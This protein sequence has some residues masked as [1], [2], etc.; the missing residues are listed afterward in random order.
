MHFIR[1]HLLVTTAILSALCTGP[2]ARAQDSN[3]NQASQGATLAPLI[4]QSEENTDPRGAI[5]GYVAKTSATASKTGTPILETQ[6]SISVITRDEI[7]AQA[8]QTLGE[9]LGYTPGVVAEPYGSDP[10]FDSPIVRGFDG[11]QMQYLNGLRMMRTAGAPPVEIYGLERVD[12][13]RGPASVMYGQGN[14]GGIINQ[15]SKRPRFENFGEAGLQAGSYDNYGAFFDV[16]GVIA[17]HDDL[18]YRL[19]GL[20]RLANAQTDELDNDRYFIAPA[21]TWKPDEDTSLT[22]LTSVQHDNPSTPSGLPPQYVI[23][24]SG[25]KLPRDFYVGD[26]DFDHSSRTLTN[27]GYE[28]EKQLNETWAF[29]QNVRYSNLDWDYRSLGMSTLGL[30]ADGRTLR[31]NATFQDESLNT[32]NVDNNLTADFSTGQLEHKV[33][34]GFDYRYFDNN[35]RTRFFQATPLDVLAPSYGGPITLISPT[36]DTRVNSDLSQ[37]GI[38]VQDE[39]AYD[40]W[41]ATLGLRQDWASTSGTSL[42]GLTGVARSLDQDDHKLTGRAGISYLFDGGIAPY[43]S[44]ATSF[45]PVAG[46]STL[47]G[48][49]YKPTEGKQWEA[50]VKYQ[51]EGWNGFFSAAVYDLKQK[52]VLRTVGGVSSQIGEVH[53]KGAELEGVVSLAQGLDLHAAYTYTDAEIGAGTDDGNRVENVPRNAASLWLNYTF[54]ED[55]ALA[56][57]G[58]GGGVRHVGQRYGNSANTYDLDG[59]TLFDAAITYRKDGFNASLNVQNIADEKYVASCS[60]FGCYYGDGRTVM[61]KLSFTW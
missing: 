45:E 57:I 37:A 1:S 8:A 32:F 31:R 55:T 47:T 56:G 6:Q 60:S 10:R 39:L 44:Y 43:V 49:P 5:D 59:V 30:A 2:A 46:A 27:L 53:V 34:F 4:L 22:I 19:T 40:R 33:L 61:G 13:L 52:N 15:I 48:D 38:Y 3:N 36:I 28:F 50:G 35:V 58:V 12:V 42:N 29:R 51:P 26:K 54:Q 18:A 21:L 7:E 41:R 9:A 24:G 11:R 14:P 16:G 17:G 25:F 23:G 20:G